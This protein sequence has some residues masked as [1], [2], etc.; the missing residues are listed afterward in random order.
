MSYDFNILFVNEEGPA[1]VQE[2]SASAYDTVWAQ[3]E[4]PT[5]QPEGI[6]RVMLAEDKLFVVLA[7]VLIIWI[8]IGALILRTDRRLDRL[9]K[10]LPTPDDDV[11]S[12]Q[13]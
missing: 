12:L 13:S 10:S 2:G 6:E 5:Q 7:V 9:E 1:S 11:A 3:T 8:G 4:V